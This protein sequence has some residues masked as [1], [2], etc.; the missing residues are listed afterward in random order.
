MSEG[1]I[2]DRRT[3]GNNLQLVWDFLLRTTGL[4]DVRA[5]LQESVQLRFFLIDQQ[6]RHQQINGQQITN[7]F[8]EVNFDALDWVPQLRALR[9]LSSHVPETFVSACSGKAE[10]WHQH[11]EEV[12]P[13]ARIVMVSVLVQYLRQINYTASITLNLDYPAGTAVNIEQFM[14]VYF[15]AYRTIPHCTIVQH[16][17]D[18]LFELDDEELRIC[19]GRS[20]VNVDQVTVEREARKPHGASEI[21]DMEIPI[22][23]KSGETHYLCMPFKSA[24]EISQA[25]VPVG[26]TRH[27]SES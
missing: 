2:G 26:Y 19:V 5:V 4:P 23:L 17:L 1:N 27:G 12:I 18:R 14:P 25:T 24:R 15:S 13:I 22:E 10:Y 16:E 7:E 11:L 20:M 8:D 21:A 9:S 6:R 3:V